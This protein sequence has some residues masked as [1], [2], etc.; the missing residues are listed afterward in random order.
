MT[1]EFRLAIQEIRTTTRTCHNALTTNCVGLVI[2]LQV[3]AAGDIDSM[4]KKGLDDQDHS[5]LKGARSVN[6]E[7][8]AEA[9][10]DIHVL[11]CPSSI[12]RLSG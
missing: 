4:P 3:S 12:R 1:I 2:C 6:R 7:A 11:A 10:V 9:T 8:T 5:H